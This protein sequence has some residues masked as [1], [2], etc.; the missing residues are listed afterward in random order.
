MAGYT[1]VG[2][3]HR[4][5]GQ[6]EGEDILIEDFAI[7]VKDT[8]FYYEEMV[9]PQL[10]SLIPVYMY[11]HSMGGLV[12]CLTAALHPLPWAGLI[13]LAPAWAPPVQYIYIYI[14]IYNLLTI[15][16]ARQL[17]RLGNKILGEGLWTY[18]QAT[19]KAPVI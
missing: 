15:Y 18:S 5:F 2:F 11:G 13:L 12:G 4:G 1:V 14:Y 3:D 8:M 10:G 6:S 16:I 17:S 19:E 9:K 7:M